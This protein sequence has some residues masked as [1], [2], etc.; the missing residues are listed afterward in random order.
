[1]STTTKNRRFDDYQQSRK[2]ER[3]RHFWKALFSVWWDVCRR[4]KPGTGP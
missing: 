3:M 1:M 2:P 4:P